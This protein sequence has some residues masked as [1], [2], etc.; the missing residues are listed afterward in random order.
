MLN[1][2]RS[3]E[4]A[5]GTFRWRIP[6]RYNLAF[7]VCDR[8]TMGGADGH[9]SQLIIDAAHGSAERYTFHMLRLLAN[10][11]ANVLDQS[12]IAPGERVAVSLRPG[13]E[14]A[15]AILAVPRMGAVLVPIPTDLGAHGLEWRL[16][17][18]GARVL[19]ADGGVLP[20]LGLARGNLPDLHTVLVPG[21]GAAGTVEFWAA[22]EA[23]SDSFAPLVTPA[24]HPAFIFY[25]DQATG[26]P[27]GAI[28]AHQAM[29]GGLPAV[30][31]SMGLFPQFGDVAWTSADWMSPDALFRAVLP[32]WHHGVPLVASPLEFEPAHALDL[33]SRHGVRA[34]Y[35]P[36]A[37]LAAL[38][39]AAAGR[40]HASPRAL[41]CGP[42]PLTAAQHERVIKAFGIHANEA[43]GTIEVGAVTANLAGMMELRPPSPGR[44]APGIMMDATD[45]RGRPLPAGER[46]ILGVAPKGPGCFLG[47]WGEDARGPAKRM[48]G[49]LLTGRL[50][51][52]DL[53][54]YIWPEPLALSEDEV[55]LDGRLIDLAEAERCLASHPQLA[56][57]AMVDRAGRDLRAFVIAKGAKPAA[58]DLASWVRLRLGERAAPARIE[59]VESLPLAVDGSV[60]RHELAAMPMRLDAPDAQDRWRG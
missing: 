59:F 2:P 35:L 1:N 41:S 5:C 46:G 34:A 58:T 51:V 3:Y 37:Q 28:L 15:V 16:R 12:G 30:E 29:A 27:A 32:A 4:E 20:A 43:W 40:P 19:I 42:D 13:I 18:S 47:Y 60:L 7:D 9:R 56:A 38:T 48:G 22:L 31:M 25:P 21:D 24:S 33:M 57:A 17:D 52:R 49:W 50:G 53:D 39:E 54:N 8:H 11:L 45:E 26:Q 55:R 44:I 10:R 36:A 14:A 6:D 23:A